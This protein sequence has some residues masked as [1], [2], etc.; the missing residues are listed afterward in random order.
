MELLFAALGGALLGFVAH[1]ALA[2]A[3]TR[4]L[5][6]LA[7]WS[8]CAAIVTW[9]VFT[10]I[11]WKSDQGW[12]WALSLVVAALTAAAVARVGTVRRREGDAALLDEFFRG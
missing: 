10:W 4:G 1:F 2:G 5:V 12:I 3:D 7:G 8:T 9:E 6:W 11:G